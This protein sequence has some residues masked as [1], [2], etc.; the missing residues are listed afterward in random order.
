MSKEY[1]RDDTVDAILLWDVIKMQI[2]ASSIKYAKEYRAKQRRTEMSLE[3]DISTIE[4]KLEGNDLSDEERGEF[5]TELT[6]RKKSLE[7]LISYKTQ[8][9]IIRSKTR[10]YNE[11]EK[12]GGKYGISRGTFFQGIEIVALTAVRATI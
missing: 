9:S 2:R 3:K 5:L 12:N 4:Q 10:W 11:G 8:G 7:L 1:E 6:L